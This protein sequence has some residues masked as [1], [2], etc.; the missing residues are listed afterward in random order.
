MKEFEK[1]WKEN[2]DKLFCPLLSHRSKQDCEKVWKAALKSVRSIILSREE[3]SD[4]LFEIAEWIEK[5]L[6]E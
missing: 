1:W 6:S 2:K 3:H 5:E 4:E